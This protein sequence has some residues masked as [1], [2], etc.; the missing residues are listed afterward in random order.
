MQRVALLLP[1]AVACIVSSEPC[2]DSVDYM[3][4]CHPEDPKDP[5]G[6]SCEDLATEFEETDPSLEEHCI[7]ALDEQRDKDEENG[8]ECP[9]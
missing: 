6:I 3:C 7:S 2:D 5:D 1:F 9:S 4:D 8:W